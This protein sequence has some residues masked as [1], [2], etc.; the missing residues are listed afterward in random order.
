M[1]NRARRQRPIPLPA[2]AGCSSISSKRTPTTAKSSSRFLKWAVT[3]G[4]KLSPAL[5]YAPLPD[6]VQ[7]RELKLLDTIKYDFAPP[8]DNFMGVSRTKSAVPPA[9]R[10]FDFSDRRKIV[11]EAAK[12]QT[13]PGTKSAGGQFGDRAF[14]WLTLLMALAVFAL[15]ALIGYELFR[16]SQ[17][18]AAKIRLAF[19]R[20]Q[21]LGSGQRRF[22]ARC[23]SSSARSFPRPSRSSSPC[24]SAS[25]PRFISPNSR[26]SGCASRSSCSSNCSPPCRASFSACGEFL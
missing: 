2:R 16:G 8:P 23:R 4:Q 19:S 12:N 6:N 13:T 25:P 9:L 5:D 21:R 24:P 10:P 20:Q 26:R 22:T 1:V 11:N 14:K 15:I 18:R 17:P 3:E 7:Q